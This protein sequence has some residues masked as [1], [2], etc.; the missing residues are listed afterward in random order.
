MID[1]GFVSR[2]GHLGNNDRS[3]I[4]RL[5][6]ESAGKSGSAENDRFAILA[7]GAAFIKNMRDVGSLSLVVT[8]GWDVPCGLAQGHS[9][10]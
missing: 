9:R 8:H 1:D 2:R 5:G 6:L 4:R 3:R 10:L 7:M